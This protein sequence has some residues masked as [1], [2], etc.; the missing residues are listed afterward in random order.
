LPG[1]DIGGAATGRERMGL[2][3]D[4]P[5]LG[6]EAAEYVVEKGGFFG[7]LR[8]FSRWRLRL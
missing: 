5:G 2:L 8:H 3:K 6:G 4:W 7:R 1:W